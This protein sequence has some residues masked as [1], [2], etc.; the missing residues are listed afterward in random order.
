VNWSLAQGSQPIETTKSRTIR[1]Q[2]DMP[3]VV[4]RVPAKQGLS[5]PSLILFVFNCLYRA[6]D[7]LAIAQ[8]TG[9]RSASRR[10][11]C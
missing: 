6:S 2:V 9:K 7:M 1:R 4:S 3:T 8:L 11:D 5:T 10:N